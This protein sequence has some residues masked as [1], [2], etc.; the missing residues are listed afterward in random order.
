MTNKI[1]ANTGN[2]ISEPIMSEPFILIVKK[3]ENPRGTN[4]HHS[5][6][7]PYHYQGKT[8]DTKANSKRQLADSKH[9]QN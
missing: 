8:T 6:H 2:S 3:I 4:R 7:S 9:R 1:L 5:S